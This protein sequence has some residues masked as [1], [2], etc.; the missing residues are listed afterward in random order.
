[1][2]HWTT[3]LI[4]KRHCGKC[5]RLDRLDNLS[6]PLGAVRHHLCNISF[7]NVDVWRQLVSSLRRYLKLL[8]IGQPADQE[9]QQCTRRCKVVRTCRRQDDGDRHH[10]SKGCV[11][12]E[13]RGQ[14]SEKSH[15]SE[16]N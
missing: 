15:M 14:A 1:M 12:K 7:N 16:L 4:L 5:E 3:R 6:L 11:L 13:R 8:P 9:N 2:Q 10:Q